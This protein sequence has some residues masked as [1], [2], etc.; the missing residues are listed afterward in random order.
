MRILVQ[1][2]EQTLEKSPFMA[3]RGWFRRFSSRHSLTRRA[4]TNKKSRAPEESTQLLNNFHIGLRK[5]ID[6]PSSRGTRNQIFLKTNFAEHQKILF[7]DNLDSQKHATYKNF[8]LSQKVVTYYGPPGE[9]HH[10]QPVDQGAGRFLQL[11]MG[12]EQV[13]WLGCDKNLDRWENG[14]TASERRILLTMWAAKAYEKLLARP[15]AIRR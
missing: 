4:R 12:E 8:L 15:D 10:W 13:A 2:E 3:S 5:F 1:E 7:Q 11:Q 9:T 14:L 6:A